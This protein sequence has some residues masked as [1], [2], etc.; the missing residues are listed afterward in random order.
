MGLYL[1]CRKGV[2][3]CNLEDIEV[4]LKNEMRTITES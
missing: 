2:K 3:D 1:S 4:A